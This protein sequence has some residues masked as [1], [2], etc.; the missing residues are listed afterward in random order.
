[1]RILCTVRHSKCNILNSNDSHSNDKKKNCTKQ[2]SKTVLLQVQILDLFTIG[3]THVIKIVFEK[4]K[5][6]ELDTHIMFFL[7]VVKVHV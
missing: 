3:L 5:M 1:M 4:H 7:T 2:K 6:N